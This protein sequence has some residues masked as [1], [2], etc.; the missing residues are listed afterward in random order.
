MRT[1]RTMTEEEKQILKDQ[2]NDMIKNHVGPLLKSAGFKKKR[3]NFHTVAGDVDWC[4]SFEKS[5]W[6]IDEDYRALDFSIQVG[7][8]CAEYQMYG[9]GTIREF[10]S[11]FECPLGA[12]TG[13]FKEKKHINESFKFRLNHDY[14]KTKDLVCSTLKDYVLPTLDKI[15]HK[16]DFLE[17]VITYS[18]PWYKRMLKTINTKILKKPDNGIFHVYDSNLYTIYMI[19]GKYKEAKALKKKIIRQRKRWGFTFDSMD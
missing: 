2:Y 4:I 18:L 11:A 13:M 3:T 9:R 8:T 14:A 10:P 5:R 12:E 15:R 16:E 7:V 6:G 19:C 1:I 17:Y